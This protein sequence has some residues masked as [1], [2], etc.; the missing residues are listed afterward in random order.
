MRI[1]K[2][3]SFCKINLSL[4]VLKKLRSG[5]HN[6]KSLITFC[7]LYDVISIHKI[8]GQKDKISFSGRFKKKINKKS[9]TVTKVLYLLRKKNFFKK[10]AFKI[11]IKKNIPHGSGLGGGSSNAAN[12]LN[13]FNSKMYL[14]L[15]K[16][17]IT[18]MASQVGFDV[19]VNL[20]KKN[21]LLT[22]KE[23]KILRIKQKFRF[24]ILIV[25]PNLICSTK[26]MYQKNKRLSKAKPQSSF[27][28]KNKKK[29][30]NFLKN[31]NNDL[32]NTVINTY[33]KIGKI[34]DFIKIQNGCYLSRI[35]GSGSACIGIFSNM[36]NA[37]FAQR[38][39]K[40]KFPKCWTVVSK[41]I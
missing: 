16:K 17:E 27:Y 35:T 37:I 41:S 7:D 36:K 5:Y 20:E 40:L 14:K 39:I 32:E 29:L 9:N 23:G 4:R 21:S 31:E 34:I 13:F 8:K 12:L 28:I 25:Y 6:I 18:K 15:D 19:P 24:N 1:F 38:L 11:N 26:K 30:I 2:I 3:K 10:Q 33:P 22:G